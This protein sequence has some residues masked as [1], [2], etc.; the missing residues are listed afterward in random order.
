M[1]THIYGNAPVEAATTSEAPIADPARVLVVADNDDIRTVVAVFVE[2]DPRMQ[3]AGEARDGAEALQMA[4]EIQPDA[5]ILD[6][7]MPGMDAI[8]TLRLLRERCPA[9]T[10]AMYSNGTERAQDALDLG[11]HAWFTKD[12]PITELLD[13]LHLLAEGGTSDAGPA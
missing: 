2:T 3:L 5:V 13:A 6:V 12:Q 4:S 11:A 9:A 1:A 8:D 7:Q 10:V